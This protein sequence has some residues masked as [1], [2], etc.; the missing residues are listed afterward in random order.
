[1]E[2]YP[3]WACFVLICRCDEP[4]CVADN[5]NWTWWKYQM[6]LESFLPPL[7]ECIIWDLHDISWDNMQVYYGYACRMKVYFNCM[8]Y[9]GLLY[10]K[11]PVFV[12][13]WGP[14][15]A[16]EAPATHDVTIPSW[17][18]QNDVT[19][20]FWRNHDVFIMPCVRCVYG[21]VWHPVH[22]WQSIRTG[23][24]MSYRDST[25]ACEPSI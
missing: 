5:K 14:A 25:C 19:T 17:L 11:C 7:N 18:R 1:M 2:K 15:V 9:G 8:R 4:V 6:E 3:T 16:F 21:Y 24:F 13:V 12:R 22:C 20:S 23:S 10:L